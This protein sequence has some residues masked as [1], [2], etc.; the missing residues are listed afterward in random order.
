[1][2][3]PGADHVL[4]CLDPSLPRGVA[5]ERRF[6]CSCGM[7]FYGFDGA[8]IRAFRLHSPDGRLRRADHA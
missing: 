8:V 1:M 4:R 5:K 7:G 2:P 6:V 3:S